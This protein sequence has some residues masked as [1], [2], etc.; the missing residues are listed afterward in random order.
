LV[1]RAWDVFN[2]SSSITLQCK[3]M[4]PRSIQV[5][6][7]QT[8]P[9]PVRGQALFKASLK[10]PTQ[11]AEWHLTLFTIGGQRVRSFEKTINEPALRSMEIEWDGRDERG[12]AL[13]SGVYVFVL[14]IKTQEGIW[15]QKHGRL[16]VL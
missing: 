13:G 14:R 4:I 16:V 8:I 3:V 12:N 6:S 1:I 2:N 11:G 7:L 5:L 10:G 15:T 9:N